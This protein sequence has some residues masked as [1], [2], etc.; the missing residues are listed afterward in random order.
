MLGFLTYERGAAAAR[1]SFGGSAVS[2]KS[3]SRTQEHTIRSTLIRG[4]LPL[5]SVKVDKYP[6]AQRGNN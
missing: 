3:D 1:I 2:V 4:K 5:I 6:S